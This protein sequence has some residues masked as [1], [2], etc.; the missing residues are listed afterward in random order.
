[1]TK[2]KATSTA[3]TPD[4]SAT[5]DGLITIASRLIALMEKETALLRAMKPQAIAELQEEKQRLVRAY[6]DRSRAIT[7]HHEALAALDAAVREELGR[8]IV[9][10]E[11]AVRDN[12]TALRAAH[13]ANEHVLLAI[14]EVIET[15]RSRTGTYGADG[16][17]AGNGKGGRDAVTLSVDGHI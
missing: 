7:T 4:L 13:D 14:V 5:A 15:Q 2:T 3:V 6:E 1:M 8:T 10:F 9:K 12:A 16:S 17:R 11:A